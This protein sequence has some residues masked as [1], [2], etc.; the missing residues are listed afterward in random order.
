MYELCDSF[1]RRCFSQRDAFVMRA[2]YALS[3]RKMLKRSIMNKTRLLSAQERNSSACGF[4]AMLRALSSAGAYPF[5]LPGDSLISIIQT[6][7][8]AVLLTPERVYKLKKPKDFGFF[9]Y[10]TPAL[11]RHFC[12]EE[13]RLNRR[14]APQVY[15][16]VAPVLAFSNGQVRF[17][18]TYP[19][20]DVPMPG[21][22]LDGGYVIDY[23][24]VMVR[25][26][27]EAMLESRVRHGTAQPA[28]LAEIARYVAAFHA[29][30]QTDEHI[31][32]F[33][34]LGVIRGNWEENFAQMRP[35]IGRTL[36]APT[37]DRISDYIYRFLDER[38]SLFASRVRDNRIRD[39]HGDLRLQHIYILDA[40]NDPTHRLAIL[41][42]IEFNER[43]RYGDVA[44]EIA[45]LTMELDAASRTDL[46]R[47]FVESYVAETGDQALRE[48][49]PFYACYRACVRGKVLS[50]QLDEPE[51][52]ETQREL[53]RVHATS[54]F[55]QAASYAS[56][57]TRP[58]LLLVGGL[59]GVGKSTLALALQHELG[60]ALF[61]SDAVRKHLAHLDP[62]QPRA[63]AFGQGIYTPAWTART[64]RTLLHEASAALANGRS[65][66]LDASFLQRTD[67][68]ATAR[69][70]AAHRANAMFVECD[71]P[72]EVSLE[73]LARRWKLRTEGSQ[74]LEEESLRASDG[75]PDLYDAQCAVYEPFVSA[76]E[77]GIQ[78]LVVTTTLPL[79]ANVEQVL[80]A[81][82][83]PRFACWL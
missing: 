28:L 74:G 60:W 38:V 39:C 59:M 13:A 4:A 64:Y 54:L 21:S 11:R 46:S 53:A 44:S 71:C 24:V 10:S 9:D 62:A 17:G 33:G 31:A 67:R 73:R 66:L 61:S 5:A 76:E 3:S 29:A 37:F 2:L 32:S 79:V 12:G 26:P 55:A 75:R 30:T 51:V 22:T 15:L 40:D 68:L 47:A 63:D 65:A 58:T 48:V 1:V 56:G 41:D 83:T 23:A 72:R 77:P 36:D 27:D 34:L 35:Y 20:D 82:H 25:L 78:H 57:P 70:A 43:F 49:L 69:A 16:G 19:P 52:P 18:P 42:G 80:D 8:S 50:F 14:L 6:H 81:L 45:F 7:A